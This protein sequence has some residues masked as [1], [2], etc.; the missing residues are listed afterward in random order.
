MIKLYNIDHLSLDETFLCG[1]C[2]RWEKDENGVFWG[3]VK[4]HAAKMY[5]HDENTIYLESSNPDLIFWSRYLSFSSDY[6][7]IE[8]A[9]WTNELLRPSIEK[10]RG[11]RILK[12]DLWETIITFIISANN[13]IP[14]IKKIVS[15]LCENFGERIE[16]EGKTFFGFPTPETLAKLSVDDL[17]IIRAGFRDKYLLDAAQ[18]VVSGEISLDAIQT[19]ND[20]DAKKELMKINGVGNKVADC[21]LLFALGRYKTFPQD[22]WIKRILADLYGVEEKDIPVFAKKTF[23]NF[24]G[25][26]QQYLYYYYAVKKADIAG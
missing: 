3:V 20:K 17:K 19:M 16:F 4:N 22:V 18:K 21:V 2:F 5:Y 11:I 12:Q 25:V 13:N 9:L 6:N 7:V 23:G 26:A 24:G 15:A 10:G 14:R 1:Q 8:E